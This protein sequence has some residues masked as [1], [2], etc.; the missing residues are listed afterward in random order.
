MPN[1]RGGNKGLAAN[2]M[3]D[4]FLAG[5]LGRMRDGRDRYLSTLRKIFEW[6]ELSAHFCCLM[7]VHCAAHVR[8]DRIDGHKADVANLFGDTLKSL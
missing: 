3:V 6:T 4:C 8:R 2:E 5:V 1:P 7:T